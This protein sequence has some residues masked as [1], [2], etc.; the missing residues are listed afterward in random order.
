M[1]NDT[2]I[3]ATV[4]NALFENVKNDMSSMK[5]YFDR[6]GVRLTDLTNNSLYDTGLTDTEKSMI[7]ECVAL[8][9]NVKTFY[10]SNM[11]T[12]KTFYGWS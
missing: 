5:S 4:F 12:S 9:I 6:I 3:S 8:L 2:V 11:V 10:A 1:P 7:S